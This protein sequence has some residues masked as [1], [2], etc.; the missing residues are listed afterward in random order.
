MIESAKQPEPSLP[1]HNGIIP[2]AREIVAAEP[3]EEL[4]LHGTNEDFLKSLLPCFKQM[5]T[6]DRL[7]FTIKLMKSMHQAVYGRNE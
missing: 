5:G 3:D 7:A 4:I 2:P 6:R 1:E